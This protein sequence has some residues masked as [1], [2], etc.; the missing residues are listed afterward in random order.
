MN[1]KEEI[2]PSAPDS[3]PS[4][5]TVTAVVATAHSADD[6][7]D[8]TVTTTTTATTPPRRNHQHNHGIVVD[9]SASASN[10]AGAEEEVEPTAP[11][12]ADHPVETEECE[13][14]EAKDM[15]P[16]ALPMTTTTTKVSLS[17]TSVQ[18]I[19]KETAIIS[20][21]KLTLTTTTTFTTAPV[22]TTVTHK[23]EQQPKQQ[24]KQPHMKQ[25]PSPPSS[26]PRGGDLHNS[27]NGNNGHINSKLH[28]LAD[29]VRRLT[30]QVHARDR[31]I[32]GMKEKWSRCVDLEI[33]VSA[34]QRLM[35]DTVDHN[36]GLTDIVYDL[37]VQLASREDYQVQSQS[38][39]QVQSVQQPLDNTDNGS[40]NS[41]TMHE[42][43]LQQERDHTLLQAGELSM[44][45][46]DTR[47]VEDELR[48]ELED[49]LATIQ[50]QYQQYYQNYSNSNHPYHNTGNHTQNNQNK[51][52]ASNTHGVG[53]GNVPTA[54]QSQSQSHQSGLQS[55][56]HIHSATYRAV[57]PDYKSNTNNNTHHNNNSYF[58]W[59]GRSQTETQTRTATAPV[60]SKPAAPIPGWMMEYLHHDLTESTTEDDDDDELS[61]S[62]HGSGASPFPAHVTVH[63]KKKV[64]AVTTA[65]MDHTMDMDT[66]ETNELF[67]LEHFAD[68]ELTDGLEEDGLAL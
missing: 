33:E 34:K 49:V 17:P 13:A 28:V 14:T 54:A 7:S 27:H 31:Q 56:S 67:P 32:K 41:A 66:M 21:D 51:Y 35:Q 61:D 47:A 19:P 12:E 48:D 42:H 20:K 40:V 10:E 65:T 57:S 68:V 63:N 25:Q 43:P 26:P 8:S 62:E 39:S 60:V 11:E 52:L 16:V 23:V 64:V 44:K 37:N 1:S 6:R 50:Q 4:I 58:S 38:Q 3:T 36:E 22:T 2:P 15:S 55:P 24:P 30:E 59:P 29:T 46:A 53:H 9:S 5:A 18:D 45:L